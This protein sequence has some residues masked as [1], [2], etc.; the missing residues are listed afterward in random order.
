MLVSA[1]SGGRGANLD[2]HGLIVLLLFASHSGR[3]ARQMYTR[4]REDEARL[5]TSTILADTAVIRFKRSRLLQLLRE[6]D[7]LQE[8]VNSAQRTL[9]QNLDNL[10]IVEA[11]VHWLRLKVQRLES[12]APLTARVLSTVTSYTSAGASTS[13]SGTSMHQQRWRRRSVN[14]DDT[15]DVALR[16]QIPSGVSGALRYMSADNSPPYPPEASSVTVNTPQNSNH[17][18]SQDWEST[19]LNRR[20]FPKQLLKEC[21]KLSQESDNT[22]SDPA[23]NASA[24]PTTLP[25]RLQTH[26]GSASQDVHIPS[27]LPHAH[28]A[29]TPSIAMASAVP[30]VGRLPDG[31]YSVLLL[32]STPSPVPYDQFESVLVQSRQNMFYTTVQNNPDGSLTPITNYQSVVPL[33]RRQTVAGARDQLSLEPLS[34]SSIAP[35]SSTAAVRLRSPSPIAADGRGQSMPAISFVVPSNSQ[36]QLRRSV[37]HTTPQCMLPDAT[38]EILEPIR[39]ESPMKN[40]NDLTIWYYTQSQAFLDYPRPLPASLSVGTVYIHT[41]IAARSRQAWVWTANCTSQRFQGGDVAFV[42]PNHFDRYLWVAEEGKPTWITLPTLK[43]YM[44]SKASG[45]DVVKVKAEA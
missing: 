40:A 4:N 15:Q 21:V 34:I 28:R 1:N 26:R 38:A 30:G 6:I 2:A 42:H 37:R 13:G 45:L 8:T 44:K 17:R 18:R 11:E 22:H 5:V 25:V 35:N 32:S 41:N 9:Y 20:E 7:P 31:T 16:S 27:I 12:L 23:H 24:L 14:S 19:Y 39:A 36:S 33:A 29:P 43:S 10:A 3:N